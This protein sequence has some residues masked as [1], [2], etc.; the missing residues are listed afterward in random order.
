MHLYLLAFITLIV[1]M[2]LA[3]GAPKMVQ[4]KQPPTPPLTST[5]PTYPD[6]DPWPSTAAL[7]VIK[8]RSGP[9]EKRQ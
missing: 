7:M 5:P 4:P 6:P 8:E 3:F 2:K 1:P 9:M